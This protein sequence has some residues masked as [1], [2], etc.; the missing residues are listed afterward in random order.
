T[1]RLGAKTERRL[2]EAYGSAREAV[3]DADNWAKQGLVSVRVA[4]AF[5][6]RIWEQEARQEWDAAQR[7]DMRVLLWSEPH[8]PARLREIEAAPSFLYAYGDTSLVHAP[9]VAVVGSRQCSTYGK[10]VAFTFAEELAHAGITVV[11][12]FAQG[13]D[14]HAHNGALEGIGSTMAVMGTGLDIVYPARQQSLWQKL[15][16]TGC[17]LSEFAP[18]TPPDGKNFPRRNRIISGLSLAVVVVEAALQSGS[19]ITASLALEQNREVFVVPGSIFEPNFA[20]GHALLRDGARVVR[21]SEDVL[22]DLELSAAPLRHRHGETGAAAAPPEKQAGTVWSGGTELEDAVVRYLTQQNRVH[23]DVFLRELPGS[24]Q[25]INH[26][27]LML[28]MQEIV[29]KFPGMYY[30]LAPHVRVEGE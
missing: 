13:I 29:E 23:V 6:S 3:A 11:S 16:R 28:E 18:G 26:A 17:L 14:S 24:S 20:G 21:S 2:C 4:R 22:Q 19:L 9:S 5:A 8:Y 7:L 30:G 12:G 27:L 1:P 10:Q 15:A 25:A